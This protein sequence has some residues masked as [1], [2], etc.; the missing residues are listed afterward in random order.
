MKMF[1]GKVEDNKGKCRD[2][3]AGMRSDMSKDRERGRVQRARKA[4]CAPW[5]RCFR[6]S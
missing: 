3:D 5:F 4:W 1:V 6:G 2:E